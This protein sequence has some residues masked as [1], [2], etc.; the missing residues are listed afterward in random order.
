MNRHTRTDSNFTMTNEQINQ[1]LSSITG[2]KEVCD[3][4]GSMD[5]VMPIA[6]KFRVGAS[7]SGTV[8]IWL[9]FKYDYKNKDLSDYKQIV[10]HTCAT[11]DLARGISIGLI[12]TLSDW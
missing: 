6:N 2:M 1:K 3:F 12:K 11:N 4:C 5:I 10:L 7:P 8:G 9:I